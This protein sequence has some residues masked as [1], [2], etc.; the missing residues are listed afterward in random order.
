MQQIDSRETSV[1][2]GR[3]FFPRFGGSFGFSLEVVFLCSFF[4]GWG[5][6]L[7]WGLGFFLELK[8]SDRSLCTAL[9]HII[10]LKLC[11]KSLETKSE[12]SQEPRFLVGLTLF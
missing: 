5:G 9:P 11:K 2:Q 3:F 12:S 8:N 7:G 6:G 4:T 10:N 1:F